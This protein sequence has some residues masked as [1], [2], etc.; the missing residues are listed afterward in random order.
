M[1]NATSLP[2]ANISAADRDIL[3]PV[4]RGAR[5]LRKTLAT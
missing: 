2:N 4:S 1:S 5:A 3:S